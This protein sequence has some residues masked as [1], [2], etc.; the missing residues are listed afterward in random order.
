M[1]PSLQFPKIHSL[2]LA[3]HKGEA[4]TEGVNWWNKT[5]VKEPAGY[6]TLASLEGAQMS[7]GWMDLAA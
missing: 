5:V 3:W 1:S 4:F 2:Q 7:R 6:W